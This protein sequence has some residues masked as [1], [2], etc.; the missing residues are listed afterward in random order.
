VPWDKLVD[1]KK[2]YALTLDWE[3]IPAR[4]KHLVSIRCQARAH[5]RET[6]GFASQS[7]R[8]I[9]STSQYLFDSTLH[10]DVTLFDFSTSVVHPE[11]I[12]GSDE[13]AFE[14]VR[15]DFFLLHVSSELVLH[16]SQ[17]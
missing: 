10:E 5:R 7:V 12:R 11:A 15:R 2:E 17:C 4:R 16:K 13:R 14:E 1:C 9:P 6:V 8:Y 3:E